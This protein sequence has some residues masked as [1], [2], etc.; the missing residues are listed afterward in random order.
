METSNTA[1]AEPITD[2]A[3]ILEE[4]E[5]QEG[6]VV[7]E[8]RLGDVITDDNAPMFCTWKIGTY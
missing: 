2:L 4:L 1:V 7:D 3:S 6:S 5:Q 8:P